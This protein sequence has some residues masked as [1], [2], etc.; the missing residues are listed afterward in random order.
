MTYMKQFTAVALVGG[1]VLAGCTE[2]APVAK[3]YTLICLSQT[4]AKGTYVRS[5]GQVE[6]NGLLSF[7]PAAGGDVRGAVLMNACAER[8]HMAAGTMPKLTG[9]NPVMRKGKLAVPTGYNLSAADRALWPTLTLAQQ[10][11][12]LAFLK[13]G[14]TIQSS[15]LKD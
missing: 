14:S 6:P 7:R 13:S 8:H 5:A 12:A 1:F 3:D 2:T 11:R 10:K 15:L 4:G 9:G